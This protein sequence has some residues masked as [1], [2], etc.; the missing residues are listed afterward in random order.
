MPTSTAA[1]D[2]P[3]TGSVAPLVDPAASPLLVSIVGAECTGKTTLARALAERLPAIWIPERLREFVDAHG[4]TPTVSEQAGIVRDQVAREVDALER[5]ARAGLRWVLC[6]SS[7]LVT[8]VYSMELFGDD[9]LL[10]MAVAHQRSYA[11]TLWTGIDVDWQ[12]DGLQRDG[13]DARGAFHARLRAVLL[14]HRIEH[15]SLVGDAKTRLASA[16]TAVFA[17]GRVEFPAR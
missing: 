7:P 11:L 1:G 10:P 9:T 8:A 2:R 4:R 15:R 5:A 13:P 14:A 3:A 12:A 6:D 16:E 17:A